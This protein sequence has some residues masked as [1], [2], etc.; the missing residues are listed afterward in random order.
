MLPSA[1]PTLLVASNLGNPR[2]GTEFGPGVLQ[3]LKFAEWL[4]QEHIQLHVVESLEFIAKSLEL[5]RAAEFL[6]DHYACM[7][8]L[9]FSAIQH[10]V[11]FFVM[12]GDHSCAVGSWSGVLDALPD[13]AE[14]GLVWVDAHLDSHT[15]ETTHSG[16][17][18]GMPL[19][20][21]LGRGNGKLKALYP[22]KSRLKP[23]NVL[24][25][26][27]R[28]Y[29]DEER[30]LLDRLG[31]RWIGSEFL[32]RHENAVEWFNQEIAAHFNHC[33]YVGVSIDLDGLDP[34]IAPAVATPESLGLPDT[35]LFELIDIV[36]NQLPLIGL[37]IAEFSP[38]NELDGKTEAVIFNILKHCFKV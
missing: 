19:A 6:A 22:G 27:A 1:V 9:L 29:E 34:T 25:I 17:L 37:E 3:S 33:R 7:P 24:V 12:G 31:V 4:N 14:F 36:R 35:L 15:F 26:G 23:E 11:P 5:D 8:E 21:L 28:S 13:P 18:H 38:K 16:N 10:G 30:A 2:G 20:M 32:L